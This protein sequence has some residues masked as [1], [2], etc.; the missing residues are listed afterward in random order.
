V[1]P[2]IVN[3]GFSFVDKMVLL[4]FILSNNEKPRRN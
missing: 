4:G 1:D 3:L 2:E